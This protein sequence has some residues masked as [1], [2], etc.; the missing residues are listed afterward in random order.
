MDVITAIKTR[1]SIRSFK[2]TPVEKEK[3]NELL[4]LAMCAPSAGNQQPWHFIVVDDTGIKNKIADMHPYAKMLYDAPLGIIVLADTTLE[5]YKGYWVQDC[6]AAIMNI[7]TGAPALNLQTVW[8][9]IYPTE[10]RVKEFKDFFDLPDNIIPLGLVI[11]GYSDKKG[12]EVDRFK[13]ERIH[14]NKF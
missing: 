13:P 4:K 2:P 5:K 6:S 7:L 11:V 14:Y 1:R 9:G 10:E 8:C 3:V 12:F